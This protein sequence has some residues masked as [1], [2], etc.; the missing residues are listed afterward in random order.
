MRGVFHENYNRID[1]LLRLGYG[2]SN[3]LAPEDAWLEDVCRGP[4]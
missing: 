1:S 2:V 3:L 4:R